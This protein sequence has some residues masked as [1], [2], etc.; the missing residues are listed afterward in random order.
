MYLIKTPGFVKEFLPQLTWDSPT[1]KRTIYLTFDD[2]PHPEITPQVLNILDKFKASGTF[3]CVGENIEKFPDTFKLLQ[4]RKQGIGSHTYNHLNGWAT[5][6]LEYFKNVKRAASLAGTTLFRPPY[7]RIKPSQVPHI[8][9]HFQIIMWSVLS[10]DFDT[11][12][13]PDKCL[14]NVLKNAIDGSIVVFHDSI[15][16]ANRLLYALPRVLEHFSGLGYRFD[17][18]PRSREYMVKAFQTA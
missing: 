3:F 18:L 5:D 15:K 2:G 12:L 16:A 11:T 9:R 7:G 6:N 8:Q 1:G 13:S 14:D 10:G 17:P 4:E